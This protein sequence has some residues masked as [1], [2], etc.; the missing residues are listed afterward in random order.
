MFD[1]LR[2]IGLGAGELVRAEGRLLLARARRSLLL[3]GLI[4]LSGLAIIAGLAGLLVALGV[5][6]STVMHWGLALAIV[7]A[8]V[9]L[10][11]G[12]ALWAASRRVRRDLKREHLPVELQMQAQHAKERI[13]GTINPP[14]PPPEQPMPGEPEPRSV[15][16]RV[17]AFVASHP[18]IAAGSAMLTLAAVGPGRTL[19]LAGRGLLVASL[20]E[21]VREQFE[22]QQHAHPTHTQASERD[23][24]PPSPHPS[25]PPI[26]RTHAPS[27]ERPHTG[28]A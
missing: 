12:G 8:V 26:P 1:R 22:R 4:A 16:D 5:L 28:E 3:S 9:L 2:Q 6:L 13:A 15:Q 20:V 19:K 10:V 25:A 27:A 7:A 24:V 18:A 21:K 14:P 17:A 11:G 23:G